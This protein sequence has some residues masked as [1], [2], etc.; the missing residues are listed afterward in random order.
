MYTLSKHALINRAAPMRSSCHMKRIMASPEVLER[1][2][3][4]YHAISAMQGTQTQRASHLLRHP[5]N[6]GQHF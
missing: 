2:S 3:H 4:T 1:G 6:L 5:Q